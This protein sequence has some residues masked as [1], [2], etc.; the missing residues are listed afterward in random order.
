MID[1]FNPYCASEKLKDKKIM[2]LTVG[3]MSEEEQ[4]EVV[5]S[6]DSY[7]KS[8]AEF[9]YFDFEY[10]HNFTSGDIL[11]V[12]DINEMYEKEQLKDIVDSIKSRINNN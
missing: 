2:L 4:Q 10:L 5:D 1:R 6:I 7:F 8:I 9:L 3:Q 11:E 12:D